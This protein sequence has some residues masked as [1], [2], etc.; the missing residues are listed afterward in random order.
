MRRWRQLLQ[1]NLKIS[2]QKEQKIE[3]IIE[4]GCKAKTTLFK[5]GSTEEGGY[6]DG[7]DPGWIEKN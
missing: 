4:K 1:K 5:V 6:A 3:E 2:F 7:N